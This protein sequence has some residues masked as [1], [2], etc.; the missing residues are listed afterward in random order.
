MQDKNY[1]DEHK[2][3]T[4]QPHLTLHFEGT[5]G[6]IFEWGQ[7]PPLR[8]VSGWFKRFVEKSAT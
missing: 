1:S 2:H 8:T 4:M 3:C 5:G 6:Q 7:S